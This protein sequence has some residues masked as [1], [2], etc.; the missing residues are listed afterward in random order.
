MTDFEQKV[1][2][3]RRKG[4]SFYRIGKELRVPWQTCSA[5][6]KKMVEREEKELLDPNAPFVRRIQ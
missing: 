1:R 4:W 5:A 3:L 6:Y 2:I